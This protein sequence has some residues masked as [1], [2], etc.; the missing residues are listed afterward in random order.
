MVFPQDD[1]KTMN[2]LPSLKTLTLMSAL[3]LAVTSLSFAAFAEDGYDPEEGWKVPPPV[4]KIKNPLESNKNNLRAGKA[5][6]EKNCSSCHGSEGKGDGTKTKDLDT[7][8]GDFTTKQFQNLSDGTIFFMVNEGKDEMKAFKKKM[9][10]KQIWQ[11]I[12]YLRK[13]K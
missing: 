2:A 10:D 3:A 12:L 5:H 13:F 6:Y 9:S 11:V 1:D 7:D 8:P 4:K